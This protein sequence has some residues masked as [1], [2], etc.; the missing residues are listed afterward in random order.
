MAGHILPQLELLWFVHLLAK[1]EL[2][3]PLQ[4][5]EIAARSRT[6]RSP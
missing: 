1:G 2:A 6:L 3:Q 4:H 5:L